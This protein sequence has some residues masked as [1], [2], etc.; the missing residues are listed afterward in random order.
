MPEFLSKID[1]P[2][3]YD[4]IE[5]HQMEM[6]LKKYF[7]LSPIVEGW[8]GR[9]LNPPFKT[10]YVEKLNVP[11]WERSYKVQI[12]REDGGFEQEYRWFL[13]KGA[14]ALDQVQSAIE[15]YECWKTTP[16]SKAPDE[17]DHFGSR[18]T[19]TIDWVPVCTQCGKVL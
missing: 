5:C 16:F 2:Y 4:E 10:L 8:M 6:F 17:C 15:R 13:P 12:L 18:K 1:S 11:F 14:V 19:S 9:T 7:A 3:R